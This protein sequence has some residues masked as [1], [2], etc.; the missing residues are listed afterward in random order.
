MLKGFSGYDAAAAVPRPAAGCDP[1]EAT[2]SS[3]AAGACATLTW[4]TACSFWGFAIMHKSVQMAFL[5]WNPQSMG[6]Y[7]LA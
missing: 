2:S 4:T 5:T 7:Q 3:P 6:L 1:A